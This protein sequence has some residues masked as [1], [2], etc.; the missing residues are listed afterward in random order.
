VVDDRALV[1]GAA[2]ERAGGAAEQVLLGEP[3][4]LAVRN[5]LAVADHAPKVTLGR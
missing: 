2:A 4:D 5:G 3:V 1:V